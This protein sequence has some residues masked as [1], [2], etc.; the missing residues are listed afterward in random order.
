MLRFRSDVAAELSG[1]LAVLLPALVLRLPNLDVFTVSLPEGIRVEQLKLLSA[2][3]QAC[4][5]VF[6]NQ[7]PLALQVM[8]PTFTL[9]G[10]TLAAARSSAVIGSLVGLL[11]VYWIARQLW[12]RPAAV[13]AGLLLAL[14]PTYLKAS[15]LSLPELIA[16]APALLA[17]GAAVH[18]RKRGGRAWLLAASV[19]YGVSLLIKPVA[20]PAAIPIALLCRQRLGAR[21]RDLLLATGVGLGVVV[22]GALVV[23]L[24]RIW[25]QIVFRWQSRL[26]EGRGIDWNAAL[27]LDELRNDQLGIFALAAAGALAA[28]RRSRT[29]LLIIGAWA[30]ASLALLLVHSPLRDKHVVILLPPIALLAGYGARTIVCRAWR[31]VRRPWPRPA[32]ATVAAT[33]GAALYVATLPGLVARDAAFVTASEMLEHDPARPWYGDVTTALAATTR[34]GSFVV[35]DFPYLA[36]DA[37]RLVPPQLVESS[38]TRIRAGSLTDEVAINEASRFQ[39]EAVLLWWDRLTRLPG[40]KRWVD[41]RYRVVRVYAADHEAVT[42]LYLP[43]DADLAASRTTLASSAPT[44]SRARFGGGLVL[45]S[46]GLDSPVAAPGDHRSLTI[47][48]RATESIGPDLSAVLMLRTPAQIVW[49]SQRLPLLGNGDGLHGWT[50]DRWVVWSGLV[51]L[52]TKLAPGPYVL[53]VRVAE[54]D[55]NDFLPVQTPAGR[56][57]LATDDPK[58]LE[59][60]AIEVTGPA[61]RRR[62]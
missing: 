4:Q 57:G 3:Y 7:G 50:A 40:F 42:S 15:R 27:I 2:G 41:E 52:P 62:P 16:V 44:P 23:G 1:L 55:G 61:V 17:I 11:A 13:L 38:Q 10:Q 30:A 35:T 20:L 14:S 53:S 54:G 5:D 19:L 28:G 26:V 46:W 59:L 47:Q 31:L 8:Q 29:A 58:G 18:Y 9:F 60:A 21:R 6:C 49:T 22:L 36:F 56:P 39:P 12:D 25:E 34:P 33:V 48:W 24:P 32:A 45:E 51:S 43:A 37:N